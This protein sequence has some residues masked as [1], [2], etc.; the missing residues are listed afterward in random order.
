MSYYIPHVLLLFR[1]IDLSLSVL[2]CYRVQ[3]LNVDGGGVIR[4]EKKAAADNRYQEPAVH[5][6]IL[7][8]FSIISQT[9]S[10]DTRPTWSEK[11]LE[12]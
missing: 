6:R 11:A 2:M 10:L 12:T 3:W 9:S 7:V 5:L 8:A 1:E 4:F